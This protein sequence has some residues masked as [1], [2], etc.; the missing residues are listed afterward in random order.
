MSMFAITASRRTAKTAAIGVAAIGAILLAAPLAS[1][2]PDWEI[3]DSCTPSAAVSCVGGA[4]SYDGAPG[5]LLDLSAQTGLTC[6]STQV[7]LA[8]D[9]RYYDYQ[10]Y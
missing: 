6:W 7:Y 8:T 10:C 9:G 4:P 3:V 1:A 5:L 2:N